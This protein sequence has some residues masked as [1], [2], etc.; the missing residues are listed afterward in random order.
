[1]ASVR[2]AVAIASAPRSNCR[3]MRS[4]SGPLTRPRYA[5][6]LIGRTPAP[7]RRRRR[8]SR[9]GTDSWPRRAA[10]SAP[11]IPPAVSARE[12]RM[13]PD[14][15]GSRI[16]SSTR[17][18][19]SGSSSREQNAAV[20]QTGF[21][22]ARN[23]AAADQRHGARG[24]VRRANG[25]ATTRAT[26]CPH[27]DAIAARFHRLG[28]RDRRQDAGSRDASMV[29]PVPG[30]P[31]NSRL[32]PPL[33]AISSARRACAW[34]I[35]SARSGTLAARA[36]SA[37]DATRAQ[38]CSPRRMAHTLRAGCRR[39]APWHRH[40]RGLVG[41]RARHDHRLAGARRLDHRR[42]HAVDRTQVAGQREFA[43]ELVVVERFARHLAGGCED[44]ERD[45]RD[46]TA[47]LPSAGRPAPG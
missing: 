39:R 14:S 30:G 40:L 34:P 36:A 15:I 32:W 20:R 38:A 10:E 28:V 6:D 33:A 17:R 21:A 9:R 35:T 47:R 41:V 11:G 4:S 26:S 25:G 22:R 2:C 16:D 43:V 37:C 1:M 42:Q 45:R 13:R 29:L 18:S 19:H 44:A 8:H 24:M 3:S 46:R 31:M 7:V 23:R 5:R 27:S 12:I